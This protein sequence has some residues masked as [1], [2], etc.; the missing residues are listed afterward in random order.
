MRRTTELQQVEVICYWVAV[1]IVGGLD[2][3]ELVPASVSL[4]AYGVFLTGRLVW[5][6]YRDWRDGYG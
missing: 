3:Y 1:T 5:S 6:E 2:A 4:A